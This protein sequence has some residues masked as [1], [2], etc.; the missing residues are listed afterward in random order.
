LVKRKNG[1]TTNEALK[2]IPK[3]N[4]FAFAI[5]AIDHGL[6]IEPCWKQF[7]AIAKLQKIFTRTVNQAKLRTFNHEP[8]FKYG[9]EASKPM[10]NPCVSMKQKGIKMAK[11][12]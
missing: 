8:E 7:K 6:L 12:H 1:E 5:Y 10:N 9:F 4:P 3:D 11:G 2:V